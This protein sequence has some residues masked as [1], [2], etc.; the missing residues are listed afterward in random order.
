MNQNTVPI[1]SKL[2]PPKLAHGSSASEFSPAAGDSA[3][4]LHCASYIV[5][6]AVQFNSSVS[7]MPANLSPLFNVLVPQGTADTLLLR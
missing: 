4:T 1:W 5:G 2:L 6:E 3:D 7:A